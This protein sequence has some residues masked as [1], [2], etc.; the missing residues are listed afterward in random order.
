MSIS[1]RV[2]HGFN[3][4]VALRAVVNI[5]VAERRPLRSVVFLE[6]FLPGFELILDAVAVIT[7]ILLANWM[8]QTLAVGKNISYRFA[9]VAVGAVAFAAVFV[10][11][12]ERSGAYRAG[13]GL[14]RVKET[15]Y[16]IRASLQTFLLAFAVS[17][18]TNRL[19]SRAIVGLAF[20]LV[21]VLV[22]VEKQFVQSGMRALHARGYGVQNVII[23]GA[24]W[25]GKRIFSALTRSPR[26]G[27]NPVV[28]VDDDPA[29]TGSKVYEAS[30]QRRRSAMV[31]RGPLTRDLIRRCGATKVI[32]GIPSISRERFLSIAEVATGANAEVAFVPRHFGESDH[33]V[34]YSNIDGLL[35]ASLRSPATLNAYEVLKRGFDF[36]AAVAITLVAAPLLILLSSV[37]KLS[38][39]GAAIFVQERVGKQGKLF[40]LYKFRTMHVDAPS[41]ERSPITQSDPRITRI[42]RFLRRTS[43]DELPQLINVIKGEMSL[44]GPRPEMPFIV[45]TYTSLQ[46]QRLSVKPGITGLWQLSADRA[47][48]IHENIEYDLYYIRNRNFCMDIAILLHTVAFAAR[49]I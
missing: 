30:Y 3:K 13:N 48:L 12:M 34:E 27:L 33:F 16:L 8:Y 17:F 29:L 2:E 32:I 46:R 4:A 39:K 7:A 41:Y 10:I 1:P 23:Y 24:G 43:L 9:D 47:Y 6:R 38:S 26:V 44:V 15:E 22:A 18:L 14:L 37:V 40:K 45:G 25:T 49:G 31:L 5:D 28:L 20:L 19:F 42:G 21:L 11:I 35:L 36:T